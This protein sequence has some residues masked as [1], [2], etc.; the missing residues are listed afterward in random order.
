MGDR[1]VSYS[2]EGRQVVARALRGGGMYSGSLSTSIRGTRADGGTL[3][4][5][6][7]LGYLGFS[8]NRTRRY[9]R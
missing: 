5:V 8:D 1:P 3:Q 7:E 2:W 9:R 4:K 6:T